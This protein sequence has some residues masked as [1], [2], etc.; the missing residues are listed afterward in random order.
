LYHTEELLEAI[1]RTAPALLPRLTMCVIERPGADTTRAVA[2][3]LER[4]PDV[5]IAAVSAASDV[6][7]LIRPRLIPIDIAA[8]DEMSSFARL[9]ASLVRPGGLLVQDVHLETLGFVP[10]DRWWESIYAAATVRGMFGDRPVGV[11]FLS[12]KRGYSATFG[13]ELMDAGFDPRDVMDKAELDASVVPALAREIADR[14]PIVVDARGPAGRAIDVAAGDEPARREVDEAADL[15]AWTIAGRQELGG[16]LL[17]NAPE[18]VQFRPGSQEAA[19][20]HALIHARLDGEDGLAIAGVGARLAE[21]GAERAEVSNIA[22]RHIHGL[23]ARLTDGTAII[24]AAGA[25]H[26]DD[27]LIVARAARR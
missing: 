24:T 14:F 10:R 19:T 7:E 13:R 16:R 22:A 1:A 25:Y 2:G 9:V 26:L 15:V 20:W 5:F 3:W 21:P 27:R 23:R 4:F 6:S 8:L 12:N 17:V 11:R 18:R